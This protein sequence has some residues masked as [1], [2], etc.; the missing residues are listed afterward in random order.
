MSFSL[1][2]VLLEELHTYICMCAYIG[3]RRVDF[4]VVLLLPS[5]LSLLNFFDD[6]RY[7]SCLLL[8]HVLPFLFLPGCG[9]D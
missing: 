9:L 2:S 8:K 6:R 7:L 5:I 4:S 1:K 3:K